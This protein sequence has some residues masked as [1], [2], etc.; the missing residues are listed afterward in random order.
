MY[1]SFTVFCISS[2]SRTTSIL[3]PNNATQPLDFE[4]VP[5][6]LGNYRAV[7][8]LEQSGVHTIKAATTSAKREVTKKFDVERR[9][10]EVVGR[11]I[12]APLL[13]TLAL[14]TRGSAMNVDNLNPMLDRIFD[15]IHRKPAVDTYRLWAEEWWGGLILLLLALYWT[16]RKVLGLI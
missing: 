16:M 11:T 10:T 5:G 9:T 2:K 3:L 4:P 6:G 13:T 8:R 15:K 12:D 7:F 1:R 14:D